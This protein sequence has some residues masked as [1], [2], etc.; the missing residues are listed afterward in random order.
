MN[1]EQLLQEYQNRAEVREVAEHLTQGKDN[2]HIKGL[3][4]SSDA[5]LLASVYA[6][7]NLPII[8][9]LPNYE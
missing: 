3:I 7:T 4:G 9:V 2:I 5:F 8:A 6:H 1:L